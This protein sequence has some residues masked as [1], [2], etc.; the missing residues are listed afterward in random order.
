MTVRAALDTLM[1]LAPNYRWKE[2]DDVAVVR[3]VAS[4]TDARN[5]LNLQVQ[6]FSID[7][8]TAS[9]ALAMI[10]K[11]TAQNR[12]IEGQPIASSRKQA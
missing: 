5:A 8:G 10:L 3:P 11:I 12:P 7:S 4:W 6:P 2:M 9:E 1:G